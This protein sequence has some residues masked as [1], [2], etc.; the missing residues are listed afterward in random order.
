MRTF[1]G[2]PVLGESFKPWVVMLLPPGAFLTL[3]FML[4]AKNLIDQKIAERKRT[5]NM[6]SRIKLS[7]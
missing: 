4:G 5:A 7:A 3:G 1:F 6:E 2:I